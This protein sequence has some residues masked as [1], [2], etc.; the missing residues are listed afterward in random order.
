MQMDQYGDLNVSMSMAVNKDQFR[1]W[2]AK[3]NTPSVIVGDTDIFICF[4]ERPADD[5][6]GSDINIRNF[7]Y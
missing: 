1:G 4:D 5:E 7:P 2:A 3:D 6:T